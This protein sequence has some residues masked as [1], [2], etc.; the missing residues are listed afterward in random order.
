M[1][2]RGQ[3]LQIGPR[4]L[5]V[6]GPDIPAR[7]KQP[8]DL[9]GTWIDTGEVWAFVSVAVNARKREVFEFGLS[10]MLAGDDMVDLERS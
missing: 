5:E 1:S 9:A 8:Y 2:N 7:V 6:F 4:P 3:C 10:T